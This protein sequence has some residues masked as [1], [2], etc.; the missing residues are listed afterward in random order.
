MLGGEGRHVAGRGRKVRERWRE[1]GIKG[2]RGREW[3]ISQLSL[4]SQI[5]TLVFA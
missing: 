3:A 2:W 5:I 1:G 4:T